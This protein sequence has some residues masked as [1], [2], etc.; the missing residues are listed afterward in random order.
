MGFLDNIENDIQNT[1]FNLDQYAVSANYY[2]DGIVYDSSNL[3]HEINVVFY[4]DLIDITY[5]NTR[6][7]KIGDYTLYLK[8]NNTDI[9]GN[10]FQIIPEMGDYIEINNNLY[11]IVSES[12]D[13]INCYTCRCISYEPKSG[14]NQKNIRPFRSL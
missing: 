1:F 8:K 13:T 4:P 6:K 11:T 7:N 14:I 12:E 10:I 3:P 2:I 9:D 5:G